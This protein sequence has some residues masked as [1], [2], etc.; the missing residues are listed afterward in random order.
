MTVLT[1]RVGQI[2]IEM[3]VPEAEFLNRKFLKWSLTCVCACMCLP[4]APRLYNV[5]TQALGEGLN[6]SVYAAKSK[7]T[8]KP[9][10]AGTLSRNI[11]C[12]N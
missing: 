11:I 1:S 12:R 4:G 8:G 2:G 9:Y 7:T 3:T 6:G 10:W 5:Q